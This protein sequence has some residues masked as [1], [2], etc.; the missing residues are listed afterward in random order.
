MSSRTAITVNRPRD[1]VERLWHSDEYR[2][3]YIDDADAA[4]SFRTAPGDRGTEIHVDLEGGTTGGKLGEVVQKL[5]G[6]APLPKVKDDLRHF[7]QRVETGEIPRS[8]GSP[9]GEQAQR[10]LKQRPA[11]PLSDSEAAKAGAR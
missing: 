10:K 11:Q 9:E 7:K 6:S 2:P 1:E 4:V 3:A 8:D 5:I